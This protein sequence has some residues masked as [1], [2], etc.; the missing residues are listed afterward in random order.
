MQQAK[1]HS[2]PITALPTTGEV[3]D[4]AKAVVPQRSHLAVDIAFTYKTQ[5]HLIREAV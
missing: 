2:R 4:I 1:G 5:K 3:M